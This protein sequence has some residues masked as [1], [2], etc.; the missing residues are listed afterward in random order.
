MTRINNDKIDLV[1]QS[2][3]PN[4]PSSGELGLFAA[5]D[6]YIYKIDENGIV[7]QISA[8]SAGKTT[9]EVEDIVSALLTG[10]T[11]ISLTYD[12]ANDTLT[13]DNTATAKWYQE[14][15]TLTADTA[16][17]VTHN[18][19]VATFPIVQFWGDDDKLKDG[20]EIQKIDSDNINVTAA[21][22]ISGTVIVYGT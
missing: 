15:V 5:N 11:S 13:I 17:T 20:L 10:G 7:T 18:L 22:N 12:D 4:K 6:G 16:Y 21:V 1:K 2:S 19:S 9:E 8:G 3:N 14:N